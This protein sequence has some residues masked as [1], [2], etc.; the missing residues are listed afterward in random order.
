MG[1]FWKPAPAFP[2]NATSL[3]NFN[4]A[5]GAI[6][7]SWVANPDGVARGVFTIS[8]NATTNASGGTWMYLSS[9]TI[10]GPQDVTVDIPTFTIGSFEVDMLINPGLGTWAGYGVIYNNGGSNWEIDHYD[11][12]GPD[13]T[14]ASITT[15]AAGFAPVSG[16]SLGIR[17]LPPVIELYVKPPAGSWTRLLRAT[18]PNFIAGPYVA[19]LYAANPTGLAYDNLAGGALTVRAGSPFK[20]DRTKPQ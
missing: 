7:G 5:D 14:L 8:G 11:T 15:A 2:A 16:M 6:G 18:D 19:S 20:K 3:D 13:V 4:R 1:R 9:P 12:S 10:A 17:I